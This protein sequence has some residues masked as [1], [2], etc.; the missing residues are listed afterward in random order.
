M[1]S[2]TT[3]LENG[4]VATR[5][6]PQTVSA[7]AVAQILGR[8]DGGGAERL[9]WY[10][11]TGLERCGANVVAIALRGAEPSRA[12]NDRAAVVLA[13]PRGLPRGLLVFWL[14]RVL[15][16][17]RLDVLHCHGANALPLCATALVGLRH[18]RLCFTWHDSESVLASGSWR[19]RLTAWA[20]RR[21]ASVSGSS[22]GVAARLRDA[23]LRFR[24]VLAGEAAPH[25]GWLT[26]QVRGGVQ[27]RGLNEIVSL[28][29]WVA[30]MSALLGDAAIGV[31]T[32]HTEGLSL[33]LLEQMM[34]GMAVVATDVGDTAVAVRD[35][36]T[37]LLI[38]PGDE[39]ALTA[40]L[41]RLIVDIELRTRLGHAARE[42]VLRE[43]SVE[44]MARRA[45]A[46]YRAVLESA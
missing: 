12:A 2:A 9:A 38:P 15:S 17:L 41:R 32:S 24:V 45:L 25:L 6:A 28:P 43:F 13:P 23:G 14:R 26:E 35:G 11:T 3:A 22:A 4:P 37:G 36:E 8:F 18:P 46:E 44:V 20:L 27:N 31:Q 29:G 42:L 39:D 30:D 7:I 10:L 16:R 19:R 21:C 1:T 40:A 34:A 5:P 33:T